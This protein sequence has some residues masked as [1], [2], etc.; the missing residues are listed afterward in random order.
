VGNF[1]LF[2]DGLLEMGFIFVGGRV[3]VKGW[4]IGE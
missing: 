4:G 3:F 1:Y 2:F